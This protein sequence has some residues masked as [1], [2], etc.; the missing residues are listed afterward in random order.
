MVQA[1]RRTAERADRR[2]AFE[3]G[4]LADQRVDERRRAARKPGSATPP[5]CSRSMP[6]I[7]P[8]P[9]AQRIDDLGE[10]GGA[11]A[12][13]T[14]AGREPWQPDA[15][16]DWQPVPAMT[17]FE[18]WGVPELANYNGMIWY[19]REIE[20]TAEQARGPA[21][22][23]LGMVDDADRTWVNGVGVGGS[24]LASQSRVYALP[25]G[26]AEGRAQRHHRQRRRRLCL[27]RHDRPG[28]DDAA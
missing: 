26:S 4:R 11:P 3:L 24:S 23:V 10:I 15:A 18:T 20:L 6:A 14:R 28:G 8:P 12:R 21:T 17:N 5:T 7:P 22:L 19:Q 1:L 13:A 16:L 25:A 9:T 2:D 27:W